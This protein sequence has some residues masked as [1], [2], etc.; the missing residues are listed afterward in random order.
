MRQYQNLWNTIRDSKRASVTAPAEN[1]FRIIQAVRKERTK[2]FVWK[3]ETSE[4]RKKYELKIET[5]GSVIVFT[6]RENYL[7]GTYL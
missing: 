5:N 4:Q 1:H 7:K 6:L 3:L 2:D